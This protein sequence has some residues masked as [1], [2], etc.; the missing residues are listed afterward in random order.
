MIPWS[1]PHEWNAVNRRLAEWQITQHAALVS[2]R[3]TAERIRDRM[4]ALEAEIQ[5]LAAATCPWCPS[6]CCRSATIWYDRWDLWRLHLL[7]VPPPPSQPMRSAAGPCRYLGPRGCRLERVQRPWICTWYLC[8]TQMRRLR[9]EAGGEPPP[10]PAALAA[11]KRLRRELAATV[12]AAIGKAVL[13][14]ETPR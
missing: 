14:E 8:P 4:A 10:L 9:R 3:Q 7:A 2:A 13:E 11:V 6:P 5:R 12:E 1:T